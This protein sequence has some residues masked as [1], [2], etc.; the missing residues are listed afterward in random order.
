[1]EGILIKVTDNGK[2]MDK[3]TQQRIFEPFFSTKPVGEGTGLGLSICYGI[4]QEH[5]GIMKVQSEVGMGSTFTI[6]LP[7]IE[8]FQDNHT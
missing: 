7:I 8:K 5:R 6:W 4:V 3:E 1:M 2:G